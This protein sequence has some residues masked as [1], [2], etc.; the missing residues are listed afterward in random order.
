MCGTNERLKDS[1]RA[2]GTLVGAWVLKLYRAWLTSFTD[3][4]LDGWMNG[5]W[6]TFLHYQ[7]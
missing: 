4:R 1:R 2:Q 7:G 6:A 3:T 5:F